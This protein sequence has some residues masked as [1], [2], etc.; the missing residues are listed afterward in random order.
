LESKLRTSHLIACEA[1]LILVGSMLAIGQ[2]DQ[3]AVSV[4]IACRALEV[5]SDAEL[6]TAIII[7]HQSDQSQRNELGVLL[8][9][10]SGDMV[11]IQGSDGGWHPAHMVRL[12]SAFGRGMLMLMAPSPVAEHSQFLLRVPGGANPPKVQP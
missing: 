6:K 4:T 1:V 10:H 12:K 9:N 11:E 5:H 3:H 2:G 7:F 8:H